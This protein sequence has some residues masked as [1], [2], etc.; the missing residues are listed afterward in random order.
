MSVP[1]DLAADAQRLAVERQR[2]GRSAE[3]V[4]EQLRQVVERV[5]EAE[6]VGP[7]D[8]AADLDRPSIGRFGFVEP[9]SIDQDPGQDVERA[10]GLGMCGFSATANGRRTSGGNRMQR[11]WIGSAISR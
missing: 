7:F 6:I 10:G 8:L 2:L 11:R 5:G 3:L 9:T 4:D 1:V